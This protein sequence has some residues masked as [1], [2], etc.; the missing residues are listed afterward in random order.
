MTYSPHKTSACLM[1]RNMDCEHT[2][3]SQVAEVAA[4]LEHPTGPVK[5]S[6]ML[7]TSAAS[8]FSLQKSLL[9]VM[10]HKNL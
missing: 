8:V 7:H 9:Q 10:P 3:T 1:G 2:H 4:G 5:D 6:A